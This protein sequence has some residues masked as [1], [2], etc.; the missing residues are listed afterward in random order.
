M[1]LWARK[2]GYQLSDHHIVKRYNDEFM[3]E[4][5]PVKTERDIFNIL[6][7]EYKAPHERDI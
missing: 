2:N 7:L 5:I 6:G 1:R 3:G 4:P